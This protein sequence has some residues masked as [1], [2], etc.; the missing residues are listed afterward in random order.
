MI[1]IRFQFYSEQF[2]NLVQSSFLVISPYSLF[3][4]YVS[5]ETEN[6][7]CLFPYLT[8]TELK[9]LKNRTEF[10]Q[11]LFVQKYKKAIMTRCSS[12]LLHRPLSLA[13]SVYESKFRQ[14]KSATFTDQ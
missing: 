12:V 9:A 11:A 6:S 14:H 4:L 1:L 3:S 8:A 13:E 7:I 2:H 10:L 5:V